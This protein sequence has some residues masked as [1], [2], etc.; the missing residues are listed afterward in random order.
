MDKEKREYQCCSRRMSLSAIARA[1]TSPRLRT[2]PRR[3]WVPVGSINY[4]PANGPPRA[5]SIN[6]GDGKQ[7]WL[8]EGSIIETALTNRLN[9]SFTGPVNCLLTT[10]VY[11]HDR[12]HVLIPKGSRVL[13]EAKRNDSF[14]QQRVAVFFHRIIMP[15][16]FSVDLD[17]FRGL[18]Q[19]GET[20]S[21][22]K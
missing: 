15:D 5:P 20:A 16:G 14:G 7:Y 13:R 11:S 21:A 6:D 17:Q 8:F 10:D 22:I 4:L 3:P 1:R 2:Q 9:G 18:N 12:R 19:I